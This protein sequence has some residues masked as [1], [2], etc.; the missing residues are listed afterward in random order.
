[1]DAVVQA[2]WH[3]VVDLRAEPSQAAK[4]GLDVSARAAKSVIQIEMPE[5]GVE[6]V[7]PHQANDAAAEPD[8]FR[9]SG[10]AVDD[11]RRFN[12][13]IGL[14]LAVLGSVGRVARS[15]LAR[16]LGSWGPALGQRVANTDQEQES[17]N[18]E[19]AQ[20]RIL[21]P[22]HTATHNFLDF[23]PARAHADAAR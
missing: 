4:G 21:N 20:N 14:A 8:A 6:I 1:M 19:M 17:G 18:G 2:L 11:L 15:R 7:A 3:L 13:F 12:E 5:G 9:V 22:K 16:I 23:W 10:G